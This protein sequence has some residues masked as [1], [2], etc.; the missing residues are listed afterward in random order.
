MLSELS[1]LY[2]FLGG[3]GAGLLLVTSVMAAFVK[4]PHCTIGTQRLN[5][6]RL[7]AYRSLSRIFLPAYATSGVFIAA[8]IVC[9]FVD[10][11]MPNRALLLFLSPQLSFISVGSWLLSIAEFLCITA[12]F[13]CG[14][15]FAPFL[16]SMAVLPA[17]TGIAAFA[18]MTYTGLMLQSLAAVPLWNTWLLPC[19]FI[20]SAVSCGLAAFAAIINLSGVSHQFKPAIRA[21]ARIDMAVLALELAVA[22]LFVVTQMHAA[23]ASDNGT[24]QS[25]RLSLETLLYGPNAW[26]FFVVFIV[27]GIVVPFAIAT[28]SLISKP[29]SMA[30]LAQSACVFAGAFAM[31]WCI[32]QAGIHPLLQTAG[33]S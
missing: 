23:Q 2:L 18:V 13:L 3:V 21:I 8:G 17:L 22:I 11:G 10:L 26:I 27:L 14:R 7:A 12:L 15:G 9:L 31:R 16:D 1:V 28:I 29:C 32:V 20:A 5:G 24:V 6:N 30:A 19:L 4:P 25:L 33:L